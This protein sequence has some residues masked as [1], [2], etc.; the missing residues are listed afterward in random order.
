MI[1]SIDGQNRLIYLD[2]S[3]VNASIHPID[4]YKEMRTVRRLDSSLRQ[5]EVFLKAYGNVPK[6][7]GKATERYVQTIN[8]TTIVPF[9]S[10]QVLSVTGTIITDD[11]FE[12]VYCFNRAYL[13]PSVEVDINYIPPQV[14]VITISTGG[15]ALTAAEHDKL[16]A[17]SSDV[18]Q[19]PIR[20]VTSSGVGGATAKEVWEYG[21][22]DL[23]STISSGLNETELHTALDSYTNK[24]GYQA[25]V[26]NLSAD[27]NVVQVAGVNVVGIDDFKSTGFTTP[28][29]LSSLATEAE[30]TNNT[31][32]I[33]AGINGLNN[34]TVADIWA[35]VSRT[36]TDKTGIELASIEL[37]RIAEAVELAILNET[38]GRAVLNAI[39]G[40]IG[41]SN[42]DEIA[43]VAAI[44]VDL[45]RNTGLMD[46]INDKTINLPS[47][48]ASETVATSNKVEVIAEVNST[49]TKIDNLNDITS[50]EVVQAMQI[51]ADDFKADSID[52]SGIP[53]ALET[54]NTVWLN[55]SRTLTDTAGLTIAQEAILNDTNTKVTNLPD[56]NTI[57]DEII[58]I[59][60][61]KLSI[62]PI[63]NTMTVWD[64][65]GIVVG[66]Y[67]L[68][69]EN[70]NPDSV[71]VFERVMK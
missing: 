37:D 19:A 39:V 57:R 4:I 32:A 31:A 10:S 41:N 11:G 69:D 64:K 49:E 48:P 33:I 54:A 6:G 52:L 25:D 13:S 24:I 42:V 21:T 38:D 9:D 20:T 70:G 12:G 18:W 1:A 55:S 43:L 56:I 51:V 71:R 2:A 22:R 58:N 67:N 7:G 28:S 65:N 8:G 30:V 29:D 15:S 45:E 40:A 46:S 66:S 63:T 23:T 27:V 61:G 3:T 62:D 68:Q 60:F 34:I 44:R 59:H 16:F 26:S 5:Y 36:L 50:I 14:E 47:Y 53:T 17:V 35:S